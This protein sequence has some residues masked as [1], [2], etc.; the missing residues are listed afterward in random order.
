MRPPT[1][2]NLKTKTGKRDASCA[3]NFFYCSSGK[4]PDGT[5]LQSL[6]RYMTLLGAMQTWSS[7]GGCCGGGGVAL[8]IKLRPAAVVPAKTAFFAL[9]S[10]PKDHFILFF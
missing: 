9:L 8:C 5:P 2:G 6:A 10:H 7:P 4:K 1:P 3:R